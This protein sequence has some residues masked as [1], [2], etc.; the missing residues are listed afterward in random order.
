MSEQLDQNSPPAGGSPS[1]GAGE[2]SSDSNDKLMAAL[3][4]PIPLVGLIILISDTMKVKPFLKFHA[5][6]SLA[7]NVVLWVGFMAISFVTA[8]CGAIC[9]PVILLAMLYPAYKAYQGEMFAI[10]TLTDFIKN[11]GWA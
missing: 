5:V 4:Y 2:P 3:S 6:Q 7:L 10:P 8:G 1:Q 11:Q 9:A